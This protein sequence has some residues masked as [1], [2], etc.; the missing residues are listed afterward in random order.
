MLAASHWNS[1]EIVKLVVAGTTPVAVAV[2]AAVL[3][4]ALKQAENRQWFSQKLVEKRIELLDTAL[5]DL[6]DLLCYFTWVGN[7]KELSPTEVLERKRRLDRLFYA[8]SPFFSTTALAAYEG[9]ASVV[10]KTFVAP[11][12]SAQLRTTL[13]SRHGSRAQAFAHQ[14]DPAWASM[15]TDKAE[16]TSPEAVKERYEAL[17]AA[18][19]ADV[20]AHPIAKDAS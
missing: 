16:E 6:N 13:T 3:S 15:F 7:W 9:F 4:R 19:G 18:L 8:N 10:F 11:G 5:P 1:L 2:L 17:T 20:G 12:T 14:W